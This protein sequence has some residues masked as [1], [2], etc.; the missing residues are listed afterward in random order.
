MSEPRR[1][2]E[3]LYVVTR[4]GVNAFILLEKRQ[5]TLVD[6]GLP[7]SA[8]ALGTAVQEL[9]RRVDEIKHV[10]LTHCHAD[11]A[12]SA[13]ALT[14]MAP[15]AVYAHAADAALLREGSCL[16][17]V[18]PHGATGRL[19]RPLLRTVPGRIDPV[20]VD[21]ELADGDE[22]ELA[23]GLRVVHTPG[24]TAGHVSLVAPARGVVLAADAASNLLGVGLAPLNEDEQLART[25]LRRLLDAASGCDVV[26]FGHGREASTAKLAA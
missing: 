20:V 23:G 2:A 11:H 13:A 9:G 21:H 14:R 5:V 18:Q 7:G 10:V 4:R 16:R 26:C 12:G 1:V 6:T 19:I 17:P 22:L 15:A 8:L 25:S 3:D 24:H